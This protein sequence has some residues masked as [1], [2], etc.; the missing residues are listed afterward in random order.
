MEGLEEREKEE[1]ERYLSICH[2]IIIKQPIVIKEEKK[3]KDGVND[4]VEKDKHK[5]SK[6]L[7]LCSLNEGVNL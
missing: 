3:G 1:E 5:E 7:S 4:K 6:W 2:Y